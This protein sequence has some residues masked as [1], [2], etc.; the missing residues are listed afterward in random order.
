MRHDGTDFN[1][2]RGYTNTMMGKS[3][4]EEI[5]LAIE[6]GSRRTSPFLHFGKYFALARTWHIRGRTDRRETSGYMCR[7]RLADLRAFEKRT[8]A[9]L[10]QGGDDFIATVGSVSVFS[11][12]TATKRT[13]GKTW[14]NNRIVDDNDDNGYKLRNA[15]ASKEVLV[16]FRGHIPDD[17]CE[18]I[19]SDSGNLVG[20]LG[21]VVDEVALAWRGPRFFHTS[22][23]QCSTVHLVCGIAL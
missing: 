5:I 13:L 11:S 12:E 15:W 6:K 1:R 7:I 20:P 23:S 10:G 17:M 9:A 19:D 16:A 3:L 2:I 18:L 4:V 8:R 22:L 21:Q 14:S